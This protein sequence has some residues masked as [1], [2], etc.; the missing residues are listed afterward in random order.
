V[1]IN[2]A[3]PLKAARRNAIAKAKCFGA[4]KH[5]QW[6]NFDGCIYIRYAALLYSARSRTIYLLPF[7]KVWLGSVC[8][9]RPHGVQCLATKQNTEFTEGARKYRSFLTRLW[10]KVH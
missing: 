2:D 6:P 9:P 3:L 5:V 7:D 10:T 1:A 4:A 8:W